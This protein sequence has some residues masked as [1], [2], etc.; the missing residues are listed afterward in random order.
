MRA[1]AVVKRRAC[2]AIFMFGFLSLASPAIAG[3]D[4]GNELL[5]RCTNN[6]EQWFNQGLCYGLISGY[7]DAMQIAYTCSKIKTHGKINR[8][9]VVDVVTKFLQDNPADRHLPGVML[10]YRAFYVAFDCKP[11]SSTS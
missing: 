9:Q 7:F 11:L 6:Q 4:N 5:E 10:A 3:F 8:K 2:F 1:V